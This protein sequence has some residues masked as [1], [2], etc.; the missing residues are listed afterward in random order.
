MEHEVQKVISMG[1]LH[2]L[3]HWKVYIGT[4]AKQQAILCST[5]DILMPDITK[6]WDSTKTV[7][8]SYLRLAP[9]GM[10]VI[11]FKTGADEKQEKFV[12]PF[13]I[14]ADTSASVNGLQVQQPNMQPQFMWN[15]MQQH[16]TAEIGKVTSEITSRFERMELQR[17]I[18]DLEKKLK[19]KA[20]GASWDIIGIMDKGMEV[21]TK[22]NAIAK[23]EPGT[24]IAISGENSKAVPIDAG[25]KIEAEETAAEEVEGE[26]LRITNPK[27]IA[28][29]LETLK[30]FSAL[31]GSDENVVT[32]LYCLKELLKAKPDLYNSFVVPELAPYK[33]K[34][35]ER[36]R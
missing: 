16:M 19:E 20:K 21:F 28:V 29:Y 23:N 4:S 27:L 14:T 6:S 32:E 22:V 10:Y 33:E 1:E 36:L 15:M 13:Q 3:P 17:K 9:P 34:L 26:G 8:E 30:D 2:K 12:Y 35:N 18:D 24:K 31:F 11:H 7:L 5:D 25:K